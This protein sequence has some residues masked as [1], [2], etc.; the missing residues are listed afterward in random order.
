MISEDGTKQ[1]VSA[2]EAVTIPKEWQGI[3]QTEGY[4]KIW[5]IYSHDGK[6]LE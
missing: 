2:G 6:G 4:S 5:V 1:V 3:W